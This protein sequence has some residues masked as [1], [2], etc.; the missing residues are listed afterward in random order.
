VAVVL[1][2]VWDTPLDAAEFS[3]TLDRWA[4]QG[5]GDAVILAAVG[6]TVSAGFASDEDLLPSLESV[7]RSV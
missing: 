7:L 6:N 1:R 2:T 4:R 3:A 5:P